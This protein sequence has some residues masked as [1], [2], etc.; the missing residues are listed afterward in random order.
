M[1]SI[2]LG[3]HAAL[4]EWWLWPIAI[5]G[6]GAALLVIMP[7]SSERHNADGIGWHLG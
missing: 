6:G 3:M 7:S 4:G 1:A 2:L 5:C